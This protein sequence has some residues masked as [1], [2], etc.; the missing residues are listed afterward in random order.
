MVEAPAETSFSL[1][2]YGA[3][4]STD[5]AC[6]SNLISGG[7]VLVIGSGATMEIN[8]IHVME[9]E[10]GVSGSAAT[11]GATDVTQW[12][13]I[14][15]TGDNGTGDYTV[16]PFGVCLANTVINHTQVVVNSVSGPSTLIR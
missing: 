12:L 16:R 1:P 6:E 3:T 10:P 14:G 7:G 8:A 9:T 13:G 11:G 15:S 4:L 5:A 2:G